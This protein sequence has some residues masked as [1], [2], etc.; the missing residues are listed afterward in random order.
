MKSTV[1]NVQQRVD[2]ATRF[3]FLLTEPIADFSP[4]QSIAPLNKD[5]VD[6]LSILQNIPTKFASFKT[7]LEEYSN[8]IKPI[9]HFT[10]PANW[11]HL[12]DVPNLVSTIMSPNRVNVNLKL[13][14]LLKTSKSIVAKLG[15]TQ[16]YNKIGNLIDAAGNGGTISKEEMNDLKL[17]LQELSK[18]LE[19]GEHYLKKYGTEFEAFVECVKGPCKSQPKLISFQ[20]SV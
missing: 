5:I 4:L 10:E 9:A 15:G 20:D 11:D 1:L 12:K 18:N 3:K 13:E 17:K 14:Q 16:I 6:I 19:S 2:L 7:S 8:T